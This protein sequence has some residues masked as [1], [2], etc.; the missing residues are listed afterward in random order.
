M[1]P[2]P[3]MLAAMEALWAIPAP[4]PHSLQSAPAF[5]ALSKRCEARYG[6]GAARFALRRCGR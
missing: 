3:Q 5:I 4:G 2:D 6:R 1:T